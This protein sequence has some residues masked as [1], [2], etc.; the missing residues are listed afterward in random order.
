MSGRAGWAV[1]GWGD[2]PLLK[3]LGS[4]ASAAVEARP[5]SA[6]GSLDLEVWRLCCWAAKELQARP[7]PL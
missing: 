4:S 1:L 5:A 3:G 6:E 2:S 7:G